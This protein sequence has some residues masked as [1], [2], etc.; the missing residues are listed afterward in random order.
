MKTRTGKA[1]LNMLTSLVE[2]IV[3][4]VCGLITPRLILTTFGST[5]NGVVSSATQFLNMINILTLGITAATRVALYKPLANNDFMAVSRL[6]KAIKKYMRKIAFG[7]I[8]YAAILCV[9]YPFISQNELSNWQNASLIAIVSIGTFANYFFGINNS[10]L[11]QAAQ[12]NY[13]TNLTSIAKTISNTISVAI[14]IWLDCS[15]YIVKLGSSLVFLMAPAILSLYVKKKFNLTNKCEPD[16]TG[17]KGRK[18]TALH[19]ISNAVHD[20]APLVILTFFTDAKIISVYTVYYFVVGKIKTLL[21]VVTSGMEAA[22]GDMWAKNEIENLKQKF[23]IYEYILFTFTAVIFSCVGVLIL[24]FVAVYTKG[25]TDTNYILPVFAVLV[26]LAEAVYCIRQP[27]MTLVYATGS[28]EETKWG[29]LAEAVINIVVSVVMVNIIGIN[30]VVLGV[31][32]ANT[33][34][35]V[36]FAL[37]VSKNILK[38]SIFEVVVRCV[39]TAS[40]TA[41]VVL[42][43]FVVRSFVSFDTT[44]FG[45]IS[46]GIIMFAISATVTVV[47]SLLFYRNDFLK[48]AKIALGL[49]NKNR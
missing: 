17:I 18:A 35:T 1:F 28:F 32:V 16:D 5:Y 48:L 25:V 36:Q 43:S 3:V 33:F 27:Y 30:G 34:R 37:F 46:E 8:I 39:W 41:I 6:M 21:R 44:W 23:K 13:I 22:F 10:T 29:A 40:I 19:S 45:W 20:N 24:P 42:G 47:M 15:I 38:R 31:F 49:F 4:I 26:T 11:L 14:L 7:V 2:Q 9:I 12:C